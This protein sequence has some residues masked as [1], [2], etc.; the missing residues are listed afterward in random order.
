[1]YIHIF[2]LLIISVV[3]FLV[4]THIVAQRFADSTNILS[5]TSAERDS[6][7]ARVK[8]LKKELENTQTELKRVRTK[9][10]ASSERKLKVVTKATKLRGQV[11]SLRSKLQGTKAITAVS[12]ERVTYLVAK[13]EAT[14]AELQAARADIARRRKELHPWRRTGRLLS[15][16]P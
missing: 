4:Q 10:A 15:T 14:R 16:G 3:N 13:V 8:E 6:L 1:M 9:L 12:Q 2:F 11:T 7:M 5:S